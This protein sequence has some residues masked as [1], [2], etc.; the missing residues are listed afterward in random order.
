[1]HIHVEQE[2]A[3]PLIFGIYIVMYLVT[4]WLSFAYE[5]AVKKFEEKYPELNSRITNCFAE[6]NV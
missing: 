4:L 1:M 2:K 6:K 5:A 3:L